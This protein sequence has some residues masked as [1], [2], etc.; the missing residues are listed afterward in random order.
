MDDENYTLY[1]EGD[2][3]KGLNGSATKA[4]RSRT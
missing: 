3:R 4:R 1:N 2:A